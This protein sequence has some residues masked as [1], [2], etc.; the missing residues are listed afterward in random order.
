ARVAGEA[1]EKRLAAERE[2][3]RRNWLARVEA[4]AA[5]LLDD[6]AVLYRAGEALR[7]LGL[8]GEK[9]NGLT[10]YLALV[11][12]VT[13]AP[14]HIVVKGDSSAGKSHTVKTTLELVPD[15]L[16]I[17]LTG[18]SEKALIYD[19]RPYAHR[20]VVL[21]EAHGEGNEF[22]SYL[23]RTLISEGQI[24]YLV[25]EAGDGGV[26]SR[27]VVKEGPTNFITTTTAPELHAENETRGWSL[28]VD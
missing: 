25:A 17:D 24:R 14:V 9:E 16:H 6:P 13:D 28:L 26:R 5:P 22:T 10:L 4:E 1:E 12:Q 2:E 21:Y 8:V 20:T 11:S 27:E 19:E 23:I 15:G 18:L 3:Q 7:E